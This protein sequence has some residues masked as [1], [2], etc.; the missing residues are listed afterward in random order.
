[1]KPSNPIRSNAGKAHRRHRYPFP[2]SGRGGIWLAVLLAAG[3][4]KADNLEVGAADSPQPL[5]PPSIAIAPG[6]GVVTAGLGLVHG[7]GT[8]S[9][10]I[11]GPIQQV[12]L[13]WAGEELYP[14][15]SPAPTPADHAIVIAD[16]LVSSPLVVDDGIQIG[17]A[18]PLPQRTYYTY[19]RDITEAYVALTNNGVDPLYLELT[20]FGE[21]NSGAGLVIV[22]GDQPAEFNP[23]EIF[24]GSDIAY[25]K[26]KDKPGY[27]VYG[28]TTEPVFH[29]FTPSDTARTADLSLMFA[30]VA[31]D[32]SGVG[33]DRPNAIYLWNENGDLPG[34][35]LV[36]MLDS[37]DG[38]EWD[39]LHLN[40]PIEPGTEWIGV[41]PVSID[42][43]DPNLGEE[44]EL[45]G[46]PASLNWINSTFVITPPEEE[47][48]DCEGKVSRLELQYLG[49]IDPEEVK[50]DLKKG[51]AM[52]T[53]N[54]NEATL[55]DIADGKTFVI[56]GTAG[57]TPG[58][59]GTLGTEIVIS[60][61]GLEV[62]KFHTSCSQPIGPGLVDGLFMVVS[63]ESL[64]GGPLC[65]VPPQ[66]DEDCECDGKV[67]WLE[68]R[69]D[70]AGDPT[71][72]TYYG[73]SGP[74]LLALTPEETTDGTLL[75]T[76]RDRHNTI[77]TE[78]I[79]A[80]SDDII[81]MFHTSCSQPIGPGAT[82]GDFT[83]VSGASRNGGLLC[84]LESDY[85][86]PVNS[87]R[88]Q[89]SSDEEKGGITSSKGKITRQS[90]AVKNKPKK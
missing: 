55:Q 35:P 80:D 72:F 27:E 24:D 45:V 74:E 63:G 69:Y 29:F 66:T 43:N 61:D 50:I 42:L 31:G 81:A 38:E 48:G 86:H 84:P 1:M 13:Y 25:R 16:E 54:L 57:P 49:D 82:S 89:I 19:R 68:L 15:P 37:N 73:K 5:G 64:L 12:I 22:Y 39:T 17:S 70:G 87:S 46:K 30:S 6:T 62:S 33:D 53:L 71:T 77:G 41:Q 59:D 52:Q 75:V 28:A 83:V 36:N 20:T 7:P 10:S 56:E 58:F 11:P 23:I 90:K 65:P 78:L 51:P 79:I 67:T 26:M 21:G 44:N 76:G 40:V 85:D 88:L 18:T 2:T 34:T 32:A 47:C 14:P 60:V 4:A 9:V 3:S 8:L